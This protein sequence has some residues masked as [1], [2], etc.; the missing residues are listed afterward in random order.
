VQEL[1]RQEIE[2][3]IHMKGAIRGAAFSPR[4]EL[5]IT[6]GSTLH[7]EGAWG[8]GPGKPVSLLETPGGA[9]Y[10]EPGEF[11]ACVSEQFLALDAE[12]R[13]IFWWRTGL[14][15]NGYCCPMSGLVK[16][17]FSGTL[18][19][20]VKNM[21]RKTSLPLTFGMELGVL[22]LASL[23]PVAGGASLQPSPSEMSGDGAPVLPRT[24]LGGLPGIGFTERR[25]GTLG[26][27]SASR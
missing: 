26:D 2:S 9:Y 19:I 14:A 1:S 8:E 18:T 25:G 15:A 3:L 13:G 23:G 10:L 6:L 16:P 5:L 4:S 20:G 22:E 24:P 17:G 21:L 7:V 12:T 27:R 11:V